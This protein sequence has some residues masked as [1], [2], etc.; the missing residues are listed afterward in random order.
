MCIVSLEAIQGGRFTMSVDPPPHPPSSKGPYVLVSCRLPSF[1]PWVSSSNPLSLHGVATRE[2]GYIR[3]VL[4][5]ICQFQLRPFTLPPP[6]G[7]THLVS[8]GGGLLSAFRLSVWALI[9]SSESQWFN[10]GLWISHIV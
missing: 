7:C 9:R 8:P 6:L 2:I 10:A 1:H 5:C 3:F 4:L